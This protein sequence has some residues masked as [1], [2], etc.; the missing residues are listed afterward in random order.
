MA[1]EAPF[2]IEKRIPEAQGQ[3]LSLQA[4]LSLMGPRNCLGTSV[5]INSL[6][7]CLLNHL[8]VCSTHSNLGRSGFN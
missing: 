5:V 8:S 3:P 2:P 4:T 6:L 1:W 7:E